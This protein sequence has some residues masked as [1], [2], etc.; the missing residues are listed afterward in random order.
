MDNET[1]GL[2]E[3]NVDGAV[4][5]WDTDTLTDMLRMVSGNSNLLG[6]MMF[7]LLR[8]NDRRY[9]SPYHNREW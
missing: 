6:N 7:K 9:E 2:H 3:G 4:A 5:C 8:A 1:A